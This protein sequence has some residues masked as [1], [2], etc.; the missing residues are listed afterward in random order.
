MGRLKYKKNWVEY[1]KYKSIN[2]FSVIHTAIYFLY[3]YFSKFVLMPL[4]NHQY[5]NG[6]SIQM[7]QT[8][9]LVLF[10]ILQ[11]EDQ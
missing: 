3:L 1:I 10:E 5:Y 7:K 4:N 8:L 9:D 2:F 6:L 11:H